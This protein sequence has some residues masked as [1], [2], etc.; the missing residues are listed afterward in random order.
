MKIIKTICVALVCAFLIIGCKTATQIKSPTETLQTLNEASKKKDTATIK[1]LIS[2]GTIGLLEKN[3]KQQNK[4]VDDIL[5]KENGAPFQDLPE[6]Q[7]EVI[8]GD[9]ATVEVKNNVTGDFQKV[10][11]I[12][13]EGVWKVALDKF[14]DDVMKKMREEMSKMPANTSVNENVNQAKPPTETNTNT[15]TNKK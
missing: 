13:E 8:T 9:T 15:A 10:P 11:F 5:L 7:N 6:T 1:T 3:A 12:K 4:T 14:L 2:K